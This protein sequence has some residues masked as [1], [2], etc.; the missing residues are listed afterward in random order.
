[1]AKIG[2]MISNWLFSKKIGSDQFGNQYYLSRFK[3]ASGHNKRIVIYKGLNEPSKV[4]PKWHAWLHYMVDD[5]PSNDLT[6]EWQMF[7]LP[8]IC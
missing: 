3:N 2:T 6:Y 7:L 4:P 5:A 8:L 1:M